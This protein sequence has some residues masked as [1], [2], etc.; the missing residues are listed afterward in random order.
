MVFSVTYLVV[1]M[2]Y[3][4]EQGQHE[5]PAPFCIRLFTYIKQKVKVENIKAFDEIDALFL[6]NLP[7]PYDSMN[8]GS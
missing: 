5:R 2:P 4:K 3:K 6:L 1:K 7:S 8:C